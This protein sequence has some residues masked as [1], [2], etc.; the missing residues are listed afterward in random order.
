MIRI[1]ALAEGIAKYS[2]YHNPEHEAYRTRNPLALRAVSLRHPKLDSGIRVFRSVLDGMQA[3]IMDL[4]LKC[5][6]ASRSRLTEHSTITHLMLAYGF[7]ETM[8][9][10]VAK[11]V[12]RALNDTTVTKNTELGYF[13]DSDNG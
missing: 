1:E 11:Y 5:S 12:R 8:A 4:R 7:P 6:G 2:G 10:P 13:K 3:G 9:D